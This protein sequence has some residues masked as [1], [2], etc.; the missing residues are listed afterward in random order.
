MTNH[1]QWTLHQDDQRCGHHILV[2]SPKQTG[3]AEHPLE[4]PTGG[5][6]AAFVCPECGLVKLY[7]RSDCGREIGATPCP[8]YIRTY[9]LVYIEIGCADSNCE[10]LIKIHVGLDVAK[11]T[12]V[13]KKPMNEWIVDK[14]VQCELNHPVLLDPSK[15]YPFYRAWMPF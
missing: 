5:Q 15:T 13:S 11:G 1:I 12:L 10:S 4:T 14:S 6:S 8:Y 7:S 2:P 3:T 9:D